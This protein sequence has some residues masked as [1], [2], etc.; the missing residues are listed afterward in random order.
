M[1]NI[2]LCCNQG[3]STSLLVQKIQK[4]IASRGLDVE[5]EARPWGLAKDKVNDF[6]VVLLGPQISYALKEAQKISTGTPVQVISMADYGR[7]NAKAV[8]DNALKAMG[9]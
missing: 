2:L 1:K 4:E 7:M 5:I 3:M 9:E 8:L 6:D